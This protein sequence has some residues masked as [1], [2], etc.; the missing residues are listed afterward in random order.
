MTRIQVT[1]TTVP[2]RKAGRRLADALVSEGLA[3][4]ATLLPGAESI[5]SWKGKVRR[6]RELLL[7]IK[8][9]ARRAA[10]LRRRVLELHPYDLPEL[11]HLPV[12]GG[13]RAYLDWVEAP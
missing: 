3:A 1:L 9:P 11:L 2:D 4:C 6:D 12:A 13:H 5:Y 10:A 8:A 7:V